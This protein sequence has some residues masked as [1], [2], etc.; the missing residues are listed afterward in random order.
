MRRV[1]WSTPAIRAYNQLL[2][3]RAVWS[4]ISAERAEDRVDE[5]VLMIAHRPASGRPSLRWP[6]CREKSVRK[7][8]KIIVD[9]FDDDLLR[10][11][12]FVDARQDLDTI[13]LPVE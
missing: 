5:A 10:I 6:G 2:D 11:I 12:I 7:E 13:R 1:Q 4:L 8:H 9:A 3:D